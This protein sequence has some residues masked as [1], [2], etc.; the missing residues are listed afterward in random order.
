[1]AAIGHDT[2]ERR[3]AAIALLDADLHGL[4]QIKEVSEELQAKLSVER[5]RSVSKLSTIADDR[6]GIRTFCQNALQLT[7]AANMVDIASIVDAWEASTTRMRVRRKAEAEASLSSLPRAMPKVEIQD[8]LIRFEKLHGYKLDDKNTP[9]TSTLELIFDQVEAGELKNMSLKQMVSR[10]DAENEILGATIEKATGNIKIRRGFG[11]CAKPKSP[12]ELRRRMSVLANAYLLAQQKFPQ[13]AYLKDLKPLHWLR[14]V[15]LLGEHVLGLRATN[16]DGDPVATPELETV[17]NYDFQLRRQMVKQINEG[18]TMIEAL[19]AIRADPG[20]KER[21][22]VTPHVMSMMAGPSTAR[23]RWRDKERSRSPR[24]YPEGA[25]GWYQGQRYRP[26]GSGK[27][28]GS[29]GKK[30]ADL[31]L[32]D[33]TPDGRQICWKWNSQHERCRYDCG[34]LHVCQRCFEKHPYHSCPQ[35][36]KDTSGG[37]K[38][39][40]SAP[41]ASA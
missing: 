10:E 8:L 25:R 4:L 24:R 22:F 16:K 40:K 37:G 39:A 29:K 28:P 31:Q 20:L 2:P 19:E 21:H 27:S 36:R 7:P 26:K 6:A 34:R 13:K 32:H 12:E 3:A 33:K 23:Q 5:V 17:L 14:H 18:S 35:L 30:G 41:E 38:G 9:A 11:E 15:E 1:M